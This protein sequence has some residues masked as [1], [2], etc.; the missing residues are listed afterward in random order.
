MQKV[1]SLLLVL[2]AMSPLLKK[3]QPL[4][5]KLI[6]GANFEAKHPHT[7]HLPS[8]PITTPTNA[9]A[10][11]FSRLRFSHG[12][13]RS[14]W[15]PHRRLPCV[16]LMICCVSRL[17]PLN[18]QVGCLTWQV[19]LM[20]IALTAHCFPSLVCDLAGFTPQSAKQKT[21]LWRVYAAT[22]RLPVNEQKCPTCTH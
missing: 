2:S 4:S 20:A 1:P 11:S 17:S 22:S 6:P 15:K 16:F 21:P 19:G 10:G 7:M 18:A 12:T 3:I 13:T 9:L 14:H 5:I 8:I